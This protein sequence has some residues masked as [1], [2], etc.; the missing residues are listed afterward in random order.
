[1]PIVQKVE[2]AV[3]SLKS[4]ELSQFRAW[5]EEFDALMWDKQ[6]EEDVRSGRLDTIAKKAIADFKKGKFKEL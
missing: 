6:L 3:S 4:D 2:K 1:M 5:F